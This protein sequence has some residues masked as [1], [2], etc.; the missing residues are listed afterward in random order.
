MTAE[1]FKEM[2]MYNEPDF[3]YHG[4]V[5]SICHPEEEFY[6]RREDQKVGEGLEFS[7]IDDLLDNWLIEGKPFREILPDTVWEW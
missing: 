6:T 4:V 2:I 3:L 5:Y 1:E 7:N